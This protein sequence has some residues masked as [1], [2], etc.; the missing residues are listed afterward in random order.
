MRIVCRSENTKRE[1]QF[2]SAAREGEL[3]DLCLTGAAILCSAP[4]EIGQ[5][6]QLRFEA[7]RTGEAYDRNGR[8]VRLIQLDKTH[9]RVVCEMD[10]E[11]DHQQL[12]ALS[13]QVFCNNLI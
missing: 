8:V 9:W 11:F 12:A 10:E 7:P 6:L 5:R 1:W 13:Y 3:V 2:H 4:Y